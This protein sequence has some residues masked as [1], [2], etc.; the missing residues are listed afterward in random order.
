[1]QSWVRAVELVLIN[2]FKAACL[3]TGDELPED[4][5]VDI[6]NDFG[7]SV[8]A[9]RDIDALIKARQAGEL[10]RGTFLREIKR[11]AVLSETVDIEQE[12]KDIE[13]EGIALGMLGRG[14]NAQR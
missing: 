13:D 2:A 8:R 4:F 6:Y 5:K 3:W 1:V 14:D 11:R 12:K 9:T 7:I 10:S